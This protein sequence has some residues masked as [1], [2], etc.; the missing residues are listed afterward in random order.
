M[1]RNRV[2][3]PQ[4]K[5]SSRQKPHAV[6]KKNIAASS[7]CTF[8]ISFVS[9]VLC[10]LSSRVSSALQDIIL[11]RPVSHPA[12]IAAGQM[13]GCACCGVV[14]FSATSVCGVAQTGVHIRWVLKP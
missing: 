6:R 2:E 12:Q 5:K 14:H 1:T 9:P 11:D 13:F 4:E 3:A 10:S 8:I 7:L